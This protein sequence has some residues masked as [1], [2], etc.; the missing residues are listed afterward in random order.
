M[1]I[2]LDVFRAFSL[3]SAS[4][5]LGLGVFTQAGW[6][7]WSL[8]PKARSPKA[9]ALAEIIKCIAEMKALGVGLRGDTGSFSSPDHQM[10]EVKSYVKYDRAL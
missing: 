7:R 3:G 8:Y 5:L 1:E 2:Y 9:K 4:K 10:P 6:F